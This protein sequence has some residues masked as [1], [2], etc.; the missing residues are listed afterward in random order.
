M[1]DPSDFPPDPAKKAED[2]DLAKQAKLASELEQLRPDVEDETRVLFDAEHPENEVVEAPEPEDEVEQIDQ[3]KEAK[4]DE[5]VQQAIERL[6]AMVAVWRNVSETL[7]PLLSDK[8]GKHIETD[9]YQLTN[10]MRSNSDKLLSN[11]LNV[12]AKN[13]MEDVAR[14]NIHLRNIVERVQ[15]EAGNSD[16]AGDQTS[17][18]RY[19]ELAVELKKKEE[20]V[21]G[22]Q[23]EFSG[24][25]TEILKN[26]V[27]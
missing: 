12:I 15:T 7:T 26:T 13:V 6:T 14:A 5:L 4:R 24:L 11:S 2:A 3:D 16:R 10:I 27:L 1:S 8:I 21:Q 17:A 25:R 18:D 23:S 19:D 22:L 9:Y 20:K